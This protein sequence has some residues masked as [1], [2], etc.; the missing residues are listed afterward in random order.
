MHYTMTLWD[1]EADL[2]AFA[3]TGAHL[4]AMKKSKEIAKEIRIYT[5]DADSLPSWKEAKQLL[6]SKAKVYQF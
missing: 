6:A 3:S 5:Y 4:E 2:K 1:N